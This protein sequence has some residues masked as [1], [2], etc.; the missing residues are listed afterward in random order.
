M[1]NYERQFIGRVPPPHAHETSEYFPLST[2]DIALIQGLADLR[3]RAHALSQQSSRLVDRLGG[4]RQQYSAVL[5]QIGQLSDGQVN[6][7]ERMLPEHIDTLERKGDAVAEQLPNLA[8]NVYA[9]AAAAVLDTAP[10]R[11]RALWEKAT[12]CQLRADELPRHSPAALLP[13]ARILGVQRRLLDQ[14]LLPTPDRIAAAIGTSAVDASV[15]RVQLFADYALV[16]PED[17]RSNF[18]THIPEAQRNE[19]GILLDNAVAASGAKHDQHV[20]VQGRTKSQLETALAE[21]GAAEDRVMVKLLTDTITSLGGED[22]KRLLQE[23][24]RLGIKRVQDS[25]QHQDKMSYAARIIRGLGEMDR[26]LGGMAAMKLLAK[27]ELPDKLFTYFV[28]RLTQADEGTT[29]YLTAQTADYIDSPEKRTKNLPFLRQL[30]ARYPNQ[31]NTVLDTLAQ[32]P[33]YDPSEHQAEVFQAIEDLDSITPIIFERYRKAD[34]AGKKALAERIRQ[35]KPAFFRNT[36]IGD[37]LPFADQ[38]ILVEMVY[39]AYKPIDMSFED[40]QRLMQSV[41]DHT[42]QLDQYTFPENGYDFRPF[43]QKKFV[44]ADRKFVDGDR[45][46]GHRALLEKQL[47]TDDAGRAQLEELLVRL[48]KA[49]TEFQPAELAIMLSV[50]GGDEMV[51]R[52][53]QRYADLQPAQ[54]YQ[55]IAESQEIFGVYFDDHYHERLA[56][57]LSANPKIQAR[58][59]KILSAEDRKA[60]IKKKLGKDGKD[61]DWD[62]LAI[63]QGIAQLFG[64]LLGS[65]TLKGL[66][67]QLRTEGN[68][69]VQVDATDSDDA[70]TVQT[71]NLKAYISKNAGSFFAK[72]S[73]GICTAEDIGLFE[74]E[75]HFHINIVENDE[76]VRGNIQAYIID[77]GDG[78]QSLV[79]RG[80]NPN[81]DFLERVDAGAFCEEVLRIARKFQ[82]DN[83]LAKL[84][85]TEPLPAWHALSNREPVTRYL[86]GKYVKEKQSKPHQLQIAS[87]T[88]ISTLYHIPA[89]ETKPSK[90]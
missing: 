3:R 28:R 27:K 9:M 88:S 49:G 6:T 56:N 55:Y 10:E 39:L 7:A 38:D 47:P 13:S 89:P 68:K 36:P 33:Q 79:L 58:I 15:D 43:S 86:T 44:V 1:G 34:A 70:T 12:A 42:D 59:A 60:T 74:R 48:A 53:Q 19:I 41:E 85:I 67:E 32:I 66:R 69:F 24:G 35:L 14:K 80:F 64:T 31:F 30:I 76:T 51:R 50:M 54:Y 84:Y 52:F 81:T 82:E 17:Q 62:N 2:E 29:A 16:L 21:P 72:A 8:A 71:K 20:A 73:A 18:L 77:E 61:V 57:F 78:R 63:P 90:R 46:R 87:S 83:G 65:K 11:A 4:D 22:S 37:I 23:L 25:E 26:A 45:L 75:D 40:I 5:E